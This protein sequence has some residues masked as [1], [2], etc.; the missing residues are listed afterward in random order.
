MKRVLQGLLGLAILVAVVS[1][2]QVADSHQA[3]AVD[4]PGT[5]PQR[6]RGDDPAPAPP[7]P[8]GPYVALP[9]EIH[10]EPGAFVAVQPETNGRIV[11]FRAETKGLNLFPPNMLKDDRSTVVS[12]YAPGRYVLTAYTALGDVPSD[13]ETTTIVIAGPTPVPPSPD[14]PGPNP[15]TPP[16]P[17]NG[18]RVLI[19]EEAEDRDQLPRSQLE[20][21]DSAMN[22]ALRDW[23][24]SV[25]AKN[26]N[27]AE[28]RIIDKDEK[29]DFEAD[30]WKQ[31]RAAAQPTA[32]PWV[33]ISNGSAGFQGPL[34]ADE[35]SLKAL[36]ARYQ[37]S[38]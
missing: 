5:V 31:A 18:L 26:G 9:E 33:L 3:R 6:P 35:A 1:A 38:P 14:P 21:I 12:A 13:P 36:I 37:V 8:A 23:L 34:P 20:A 28:W 7:V 10:G 29:L 15:P 17:G 30:I 24:D 22:G 16:L 27:A 11:R 2:Q 32:Y 19:L 4:Y 25:C